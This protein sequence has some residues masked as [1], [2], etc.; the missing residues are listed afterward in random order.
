MGFG[1]FGLMGFCSSSRFDGVI[2]KISRWTPLI[3]L[4]FPT[5][6]NFRIFAARVG[7]LEG[8]RADL[9]TIDIVSSKKRVM[10]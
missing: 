2:G 9:I 10:S 6:A 3:P 7:C 4:A 8:L 1:L 5:F